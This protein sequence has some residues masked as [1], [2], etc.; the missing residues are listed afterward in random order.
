MP[1]HD[2]I[3]VG[4]GIVGLAHALAAARRGK[5]VLVIDRDAQANGASVRNFGFVTV[6]GQARDDVWALARRSAD[7][8]RSVA[9][10]AGIA[11]A[12]E[13]LTMV[14]QT[15]EGAAVLAAFVATEM[16]VGCALLDGAATEARLPMLRA[17][18]AV[19]GLASTADLRVES[20]SAIPRLADWLATHFGVAFRRGVTVQAV[21]PGAVRCADGG[22]YQADRIIVCPGDDL[23][24]LFPDRIAAHGIG[25]CLLQMVRLAPP[26]WRLPSAVMGD[27]SLARYRGFADLPAAVALRAR[28]ERERAA[29]IADGIHLIAVQSSDGTLVV[30]DSHHYAHTPPPF[31]PAATEARILDEFARL[32]GSPPPVVERWT[33]TYAVAA[34]HSIV[35]AP[36]PG[37]RLVIVTSGT[38]ASTA[39]GIAEDTFGDW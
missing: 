38:G 8:W 9:P 6:S 27:L 15:D 11:I 30:G 33:G 25:R 17:G 16:G 39:F 7:I 2:L 37:V 31:A 21:E 4:A 26:G 34:G 23:S 18:T 35:D 10:A 19:A 29:A 36:L 1:R 32:F 28:M 14:A 3:V 20:R 12:H 13:G 5:H 24:G 22:H